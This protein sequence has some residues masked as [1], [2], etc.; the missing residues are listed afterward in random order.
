MLGPPGSLQTKQYSELCAKLPGR[1]FRHHS[2]A[3]Y[4]ESAPDAPMP[5]EIA[6]AVERMLSFLISDIIETSV[7]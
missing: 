5:P 4:P 3:D 2:S 1:I 7:R 6:A